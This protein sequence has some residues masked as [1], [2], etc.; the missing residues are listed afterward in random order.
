MHSAQRLT[1]ARNPTGLSGDFR[2]IQ[3]GLGLFEGLRQCLFVHQA[4]GQR[5]QAFHPL[6]VFR[7]GGHVG[8]GAF[9]VTARS[10]WVLPFP[11]KDLPQLAAKP[12]ELV[13]PSH[14]ASL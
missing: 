13:A 4:G 8:Q 5:R 1:G 6:N 14:P 9:K 3:G 11:G 12:A 10:A 2:Q 7:P